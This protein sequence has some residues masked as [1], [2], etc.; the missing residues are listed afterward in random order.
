MLL[1]PF[2]FAAEVA[3]TAGLSL[4]GP[5]LS[6]LAWALGN[7]QGVALTNDTAYLVL[8]NPLAS[9]DQ[10]TL[11]AAARPATGKAR[12]ARSSAQVVGA[13]R[14][15]CGSRKIGQQPS[16]ALWLPVL[17]D[18]DA[19]VWV[20]GKLPDPVRAEVSNYAVNWHRLD[21]VQLGELFFFIEKHTEQMSVYQRISPGHFALI[22]VPQPKNLVAMSQVVTALTPPGV[23]VEGVLPT[24][25][26]PTLL[27]PPPK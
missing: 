5:T 15:A 8:G 6:Q 24:G 9:D 7:G 18:D 19:R 26:P 21:K 16:R 3:R 27:R 12:K 11:V 1:D 10:L 4:P 23:R 22:Q 20:G 25:G 14:M 13:F 17:T 2:V